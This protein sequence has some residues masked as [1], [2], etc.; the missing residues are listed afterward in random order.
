MLRGI[1]SAASGMI[2]LQR[3]QDALTNNLANAETAGFK[4]DSSPL[5]SFPE[6]LLE[7]IRGNQQGA[8]ARLGTISMGVYNQE[9]LPL[10]IQGSLKETNMPFDVALMDEGL[11]PTVID[12]RPVKPAA[13]FA[14]HT[15]EGE[16]QLTRNGQFAVNEN[17]ELVTSTGDFVLGKNGNRI[18]G[19]D[20]ELK[21]ISITADGEIILNPDNPQSRAA[22][23]SIGFVIVQNPSQLVKRDNG[24]F[25]LE[26][27]GPAMIADQLPAGLL[28]RHKMIE[29]SNVDMGQTITEM[30][31]NIRLYEANQKVLQTYDK[32]LEQLNSIG[33][34]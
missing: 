9:I 2:A 23:G 16:F 33:R 31:A 22:V 10:F 1:D 17:G 26:G 20:P 29:Q 5:R 24:Q 12:G 27:A 18:V 3:K 8:R 21:D 14:V 7:Q 6:M 25:T 19:L 30:M 34:V 15:R 28:I 4:Q 11:V 13:F 32:S